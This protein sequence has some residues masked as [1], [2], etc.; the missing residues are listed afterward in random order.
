V[1]FGFR[2]QIAKFFKRER[3]AAQ[4]TAQTGGGE[5]VDMMGDNAQ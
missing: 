1:L 3:A 2:R 4:N 5:V